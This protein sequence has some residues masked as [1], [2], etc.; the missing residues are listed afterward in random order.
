MAPVD[1]DNLRHE[2]LKGYN[3]RGISL[4]GYDLVNDYV[5]FVR[6]GNSNYAKVKVVKGVISDK[7]D[8]F[9]KYILLKW[10]TYNTAIC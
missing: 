2:I 1:F 8:P 5:F 3:Y 10:K 9:Y 7:N 6:T 4:T